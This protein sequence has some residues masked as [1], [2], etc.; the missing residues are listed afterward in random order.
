MPEIK[1]TALG[2]VKNEERMI[3]T[4]Y[5]SIPSHK[6]VFCGAFVYN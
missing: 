6:E 3:F 5:L 1:G 4:P 2:L